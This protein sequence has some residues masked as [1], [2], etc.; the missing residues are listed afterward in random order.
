MSH[1]VITPLPVRLARVKASFDVANVS[2]TNTHGRKSQIIGE[3]TMQGSALD[4][5]VQES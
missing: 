3:A 4:E 1:T 2:H 5:V